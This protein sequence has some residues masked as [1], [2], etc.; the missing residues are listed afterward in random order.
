[1]R[2]YASFLFA[3]EQIHPPDHPL[4]KPE[5]AE[6]VKSWAIRRISRFCAT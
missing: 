5:A 4:G 3:S 1:M 2:G 6:A